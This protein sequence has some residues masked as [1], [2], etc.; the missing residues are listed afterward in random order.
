[1][2]RSNTISVLVVGKAWEPLRNMAID[3]EGEFTYILRP[4]V[5]NISSRFVCQ[6]TVEENV[7]IVTLR[8]T[9]KVENQTL[10]PIELSLDIDSRPYMVQ[11]LGELY[12][13]V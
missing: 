8:S 7:K 13:S 10:Y 2:T 5:D 12:I 4:K 3:R 1:M 9:Y 11:K 6:V